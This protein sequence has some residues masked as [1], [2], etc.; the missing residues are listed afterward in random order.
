MAFHDVSMKFRN[1]E[2]A[3]ITAAIPTNSLGENRII[4]HELYSTMQSLGY[5]VTSVKGFYAVSTAANGRPFMPESSF[6]V[7][8]NRNK[9]GF[10]LTL[11]KLGVKYEQDSIVIFREGEGFMVGLTNKPG[12]EVSYGR[13]KA[14][15]LCRQTPQLVNY[16]D[17]IARYKYVFEAATKHEKM[18][19]CEFY[20][21][22]QENKFR[23]AIKA[24]AIIESLDEIQLPQEL[25]EAF[26]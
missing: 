14:L 21:Y 4:N 2:A 23:Q 17:K 24:K 5:S 7:V 3:V 19:L 8:N 16:M 15:R 1:V 12:V 25:V 20:A 18:N 9:S 22:E 10:F 6:V 13:T 11:M 26:S